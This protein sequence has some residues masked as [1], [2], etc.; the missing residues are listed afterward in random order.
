MHIHI[1]IPGG[2]SEVCACV[3]RAKRM[4]QLPTLD[5]AGTHPMDHEVWSHFPQIC[6]GMKPSWAT[7][8]HDHGRVS[9][10]PWSIDADTALH[11]YLVH[12][13]LHPPPRTTIGPEA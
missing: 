12:K 4:D 5:G 9:F 6:G 1:Y 13:T 3:G 8:W 11:E 7:S 10:F 2:V